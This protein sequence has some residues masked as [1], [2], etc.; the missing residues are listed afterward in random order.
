MQRTAGHYTSNTDITESVRIG[1][2][3]VIAALRGEN[4]VMLIFERVSDEPYLV[5][6]GTVP[7]EECANIVKDVP[8]EWIIDGCDVSD[9][10]IKYVRPLLSGR[11]PV[12][13][14]D[15][16]PSYMVLDKTLVVK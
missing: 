6:I 2:E 7:V 14:K 9:E 1:E 12:I 13:E 15:G 16:V 5:R 3:A 4:G 10:L 8:R 11:T